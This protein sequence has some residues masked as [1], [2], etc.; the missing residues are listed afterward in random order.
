[1]SLNNIYRFLCYNL[2]SKVYIQHFKI[3]NC[4]G[5][6]LPCYK[7]IDHTECI[8]NIFGGFGNRNSFWR[9]NVKGKSE[10]IADQIL[11]EDSFNVIAIVRSGLSI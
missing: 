8:V 3:F 2:H 10:I 9:L 5:I 6:Q 1:M 4:K 7:I 11:Y